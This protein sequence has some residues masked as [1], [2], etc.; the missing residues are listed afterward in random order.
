MDRCTRKK[1][2]FRP[3]LRLA[4]STG[5]SAFLLLA[6]LGSFAAAAQAPAPRTD[7]PLF[8]YGFN[9]A[10]L[11]IDLVQSLGFNWIKVFTPLSHRFPVNVLLRVETTVN[12]LDDLDAYGDRIYQLA[13]EQNSY[14]EAYEIG[15]EVN[16]DASYGWAAPPNAADYVTLLCL[17]YERIK[18]ADPDAVVVSGGLASTGRIPD[19]WQGH[20]GHNGFVQDERE[21]LKEFLAAGG[22]ACVDAIGYHPYGFSADYDAEP[23]V[24]SSNPAR[25][26][27]N[28]FCFRGAEKV[29]EVMQA[30]GAAEKKVWATEWGWLTTPPDDCL[31][32][33]GWQGRLWQVVTAQKQADNLV[34]AFTYA[35][36]NW[37]WMEAMF[38]FN[39]NF[40]SA[41]WYERCEQMRYYSVEGRPAEMALREME[42]VSPPAAGRLQVS[43]AAVALVGESSAQPFSHTFT[44]TLRNTGVALFTYTITAV[45]TPPT[46]TPGFTGGTLSPNTE[47]L[48][49]VTISSTKRPQGIYT[50]LLAINATSGTLGVPVTIP[51]TLA[52]F[53]DIY[54]T[55]LPAVESDSGGGTATD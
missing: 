47:A 8:G 6:L 33:P 49:P 14:V 46:M 12:D 23:D 16:L 11:D 28:G 1:T 5:L 40:K 22:G 25:N 7:A 38:V 2:P 9:I 34:G 42:K 37:P 52:L 15:N 17:A 19:D 4:A 39:L 36:E 20:A 24:A 41:P 29:F 27:A 55:Y 26:C 35:T 54:T 30:H 44:V 45:S 13:L 32:D 48:L 18:D 21:Y 50:G 10:E 31:D 43:P 3:V 53:D 51:V